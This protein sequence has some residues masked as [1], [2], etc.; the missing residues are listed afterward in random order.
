MRL[1]LL[2]AALV[3]RAAAALSTTIIDALSADPDYELLLGLLQRARL[4]PTL[5]RL[6][7]T[8]IFAPTNDA[9]KKHSLWARVLSDDSFVATDNVNEELRQQL[10][11]HIL[12]FTIDLSEESAPLQTFDTL[13]YPYKPL[14]PPSHDPPPYPPWMPIPSGTLGKKPQ[15]LRAALADEN[16]KGR[17]AVDAFGNGGTDIVKPIVNASNGAVLG[18]SDVLTPPPDLG[19]SPV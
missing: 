12:N 3:A 8:T 5:N 17:V 14:D 6:N 7:G 13:L 11:Y 10:F 18:I 19:M 16:R 15:R 9:I 2:L 4:V 1:S